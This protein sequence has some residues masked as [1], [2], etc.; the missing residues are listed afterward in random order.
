MVTYFEIK[1]VYVMSV[2]LA[3]KTKNTIILAGDKRGS[4]KAG[5]TLKNDLIKVNAI[6]NHLAIASAGSKQIGD[7]I[8]LDI[9]KMNNKEYL[10]VDDI[11]DYIKVFY[12]RLVEK[13][14]KYLMSQP[15]SFLIG[16]LKKDKTIGLYRIDNHSG[17]PNINE[18][19]IPFMIVP[20]DDVNMD[21]ASK[22]FIRNFKEFPQNYIEKTIYDISKISN[23]VS[24][25]GDKWTYDIRYNAS[26]IQRIG[27]LNKWA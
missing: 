18:I 27:R 17:Q 22:I 25:D 7:G 12:K 26:I 15:A 21:M 16:G 2:I 4:D 6:N 5:N 24:S 8:L 3:V 14:L 1:D 9:N 19:E 11:V 20:P 23:L 13:D 10:F